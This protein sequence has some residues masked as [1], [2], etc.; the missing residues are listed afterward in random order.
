MCS[1]V[2]KGYANPLM[3]RMCKITKAEKADATEKG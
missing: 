3:P 1:V 2:A